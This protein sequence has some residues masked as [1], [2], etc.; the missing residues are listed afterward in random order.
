M[1][2]WLCVQLGT[3]HPYKQANSV[4]WSHWGPRV[5]GPLFNELIPNANFNRKAKLSTIVKFLNIVRISY[6]FWQGDLKTALKQA[7]SKNVDLVAISHF[8]DLTKLMQFFIPAVLSHVPLFIL[9]C[10]PIYFS[11]KK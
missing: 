9:E 1:R 4:L 10:P 5:F 2:R 8:R 11:V 7:Q 6:R 3:W